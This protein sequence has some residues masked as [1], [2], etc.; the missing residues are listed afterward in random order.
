MNTLNR[1]GPS[2][3]PWGTPPVTGLSAADDNLLSSAN[4]PVLNPLHLPLI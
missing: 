3:D 2:T 4:Q 1:T